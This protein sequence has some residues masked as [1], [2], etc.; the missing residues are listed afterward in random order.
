MTWTP[1]PGLGV[2]LLASLLGGLVGV[3]ASSWPQAMVSRPLVSGTV[4]GALV[5]DPASGLLVGALLELLALRHHPFGA[6][7]YPDTGPAGIVAGVACAAAGGSVPALAVSAAIG[8]LLGWVGARTVHLQRGLAGRLLADRDGLAADPRGLERR[9]LLS[10]GLDVLRSSAL[11]AAFLVPAV[12]G[13]RLVPPAPTPG[14]AWLAAGGLVLAVGAG[15]GAG[16]GALAG[17]RRRWWL[18]AG[19]IA[20]G[21]A[22]LTVTP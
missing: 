22:V 6:A 5:G 19:G 12:L 20:I 21:L 17:V 7:R 16:V 1:E 18:V 15:A 8:W 9:Q 2:W 13:A 10:V 4:G 3:D 11:T 14:A